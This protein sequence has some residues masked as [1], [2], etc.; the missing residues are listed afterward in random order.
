[1]R[2]SII[3]FVS[4][5]VFAFTLNAADTA[6]KKF[7]IPKGDAAVT[8]RLFVEQSGEQVVFLVDR[9]RGVTTNA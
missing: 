7:D 1:M 3:A 8:L 9:V 4:F 5:I 6:T 2:K